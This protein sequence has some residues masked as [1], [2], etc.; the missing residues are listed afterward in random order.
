MVGSV[1]NFSRN[2]LSDWLLQRFSAIV[3][4]IYIAFSL[5]FM[6]A[7]AASYTAWVGLQHNLWMRAF[8]VLFLLSLLAHAWIG[9]WTVLTDYVNPVS[10]RLLL[11]AA[12]FLFL[13][14]L[15]IWG[16]WVIFY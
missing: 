5:W 16:L 11:Q 10:L 7:H 9:I 2:G 14:S 4:I 12:L 15:L 3:V 8:N 6:C 1:T 13:F